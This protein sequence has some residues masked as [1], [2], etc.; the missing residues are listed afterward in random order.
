MNH[1]KMMPRKNPGPSPG[2]V[3]AQHGVALFAVM[4]IVLL[5]MLLA[6][7]ASRSAL[8]NEMVVGNDADY[9]RAYEAAQA[10][11]Q[12]AEIDI[13]TSSLK[14]GV[15]CTSA[16]GYPPANP[17]CDPSLGILSLPQSDQEKQDFFDAL[18]AL[19]GNPQCR[20]AVCQ[21]RD[22]NTDPDFWSDPDTFNKKWK[23]A[24]ARYGQY[25][26]AAQA[27]NAKNPILQERAWYWIEAGELQKINS[28]SLEYPHFCVKPSVV[29]RITAV[30]EGLKP[31]TRVVLQQ[32]YFNQC[33]L[34]S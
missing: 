26:G 33:R 19:P 8:F 2:S 3:Q 18:S 5:S 16:P 1:E 17:S 34:E 27:S 10:M 14:G 31:G 32:I 9:Q 20:D 28:S 22:E 30:A 6:L 15:R 11:L 12:D 21:M 25:S 7:W 29:Y 24:G 4:V 13:R 23:P